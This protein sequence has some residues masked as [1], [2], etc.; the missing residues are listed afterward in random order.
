MLQFRTERSGRPLLPEGV[1]LSVVGGSLDDS[2]IALTHVLY[3]VRVGDIID[4]VHTCL[5]AN[6]RLPTEGHKPA[7]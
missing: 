4:V 5:P 6:S 1:F 2:Q 3:Q 7:E